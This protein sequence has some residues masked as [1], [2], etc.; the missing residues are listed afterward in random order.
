MTHLLRATPSEVLFSQRALAAIVAE[1]AEHHPDETG[2]ILLGHWHA[3]RW[4]V[5]EAI[6]PGPGA[7]RSACA[8][9]Y[10]VAYVNHLAAQLSRLYRQPLHRIGLW[11]RHPGSFD[12]FS[13]DDDSTNR[14][15]AALSPHGA[16]S[17]LV[18]LDPLFRLTAMHVP[19]DL[20]YRKLS[21]R[22]ADQLLPPQ[23]LAL[24]DPGCLAP[25]LLEA[26]SL[27]R[28]LRQLF[29][30]HPRP[31]TAVDPSL[32]DGIAPL[33]TALDRQQ[34]WGYALRASGHELQLALVERDGEGRHLLT[35]TPDA[36]GPEVLDAL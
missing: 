2:G 18:N 33:L 13:A 8:F 17:C 5:L 31:A 22:C 1:T 9:S 21:W 12:Q 24:Q 14:E 35:L 4:I 16:L 11:H 7:V 32:L 26:Q 15:F 34:R 10:D 36:C 20:L 3:D 28:R 23:S 27:S 19:S 29:C 25:E 30:H 6:D